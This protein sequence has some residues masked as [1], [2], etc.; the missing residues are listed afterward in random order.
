MAN[1]IT[2]LQSYL[3]H[4]QCVFVRK[5]YGLTRVNHIGILCN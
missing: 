2:V 3:H 4:Y 1:F 5:Q